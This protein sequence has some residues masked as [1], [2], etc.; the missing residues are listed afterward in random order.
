MKHSGTA[1]PQQKA[2]P[3]SENRV[4]VFSRSSIPC[5]GSF[6]SEP[7]ELRQEIGS[8]ST[9]TVSGVFC[10]LSNDPIDI[11][12]GLNQYAFCGNNPV[13]ERDPFG[14]AN[15]P[16][17]FGW[18]WYSFPVNSNFVAPQLLVFYLSDD[19]LAAVV[20]ATRNRLGNS[21]S[22]PYCSQ[23]NFDTVFWYNN[24]NR[25]WY[26]YHGQF[27]RGDQINYFALGM[28]DQHYNHIPYWRPVLWKA[29]LYSTFP[30]DNSTLFWYDQ[31]MCY[32]KTG[33]P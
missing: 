16:G 5:A 4:V 17:D 13:G 7:V 22:H 31:G 30:P 23:I 6:G 18:S 19:M 11:L 8:I 3:P 25:T 28:F 15:Q 20:Q 32:Q 29:V 24:G 10:W 21:T 27:Y 2:D 14:L 1:S 9:A 26:N 33:C 12:G